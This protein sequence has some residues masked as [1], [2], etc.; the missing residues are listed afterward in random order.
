[1]LN[2]FGAKIT[3]HDQLAEST[4]AKLVPFFPQAKPAWTA[5]APCSAATS[6][7]ATSPA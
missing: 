4:L 6:P 3:T 1:M 5:R 7:M 2:V